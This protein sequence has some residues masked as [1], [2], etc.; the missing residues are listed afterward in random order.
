MAISPPSNADVQRAIAHYYTSKIEAH[1]ATPQGVD[2]KDRDS[3]RLRHSQ[4][5]RLLREDRNASIADVGCGY[6]DFFS[7]LREQGFTGTYTGYDL[8]ETM[9]EFAH[10]L[11]GT[12]NDRTWVIGSMP[13]AS[14]SYVV[15][16]G[17]FNVKQNLPTTVWENY[18]DETI[19]QM[20]TMA[21]RGFGFNILSIHSD[22]ERRRDDL[23]YADPA[24]YLD[25]IANRYGRS[26]A[27]LQ[28]YGLFEFTILVRRG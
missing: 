17:I 22:P 25:R 18:I 3:Q 10:K 14:T 20:A 5:L 19:D 4:F 11:H 9:I 16:S 2:W 15:A 24:V 27:L 12:G 26:I 28:D 13:Q 1:G 21:E 7:F 23:F 6:G 8:A